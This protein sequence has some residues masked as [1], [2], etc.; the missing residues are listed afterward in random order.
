V[1]VVTRLATSISAPITFQLLN[2]KIRLLP[3]LD[4][5]VEL[6][7]VLSPLLFR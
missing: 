5:C 3:L 6:F 7:I 2:H 4:A 1:E